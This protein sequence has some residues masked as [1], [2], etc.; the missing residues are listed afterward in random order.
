M[1]IENGIR[2]NMGLANAITGHAGNTMAKDEFLKLLVTQL[3]HQ[4]PLKPME[5][6]EFASQLAQFS[7]LEQLQ[8]MNGTMEEGIMSDYMMTQSINNTLA[9]TL[10]GKTAMASGNDI[11]FSG[12][13]TDIQFKLN[14][15]AETVTITIRD[16]AGNI[17][18]TVTETGFSEG[19]NSIE[20]NGQNALGD[21]VTEGDY[22]YS[23]SAYD[24]HESTVG[25]T[26]LITGEIEGI[27]FKD[28]GIVLMINGQTISLNEVLE[29]KQ[30]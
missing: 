13:P 5:S 23:V 21:T 7:S 14:T 2:N 4:D 17:V 9:T 1:N 15:A 10:I 20:W 16:S 24:A 8:N 26:P 3:S 22:S 27:T 29:I 19:L 30:S 18:K 12:D 28:G 11:T 25:S 6:H